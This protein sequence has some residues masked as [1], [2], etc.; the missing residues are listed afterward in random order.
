[1]KSKSGAND[2]ARKT[3]TL[4]MTQEVAKEKLKGSGPV[5]KLLKA[6]T[7]ERDQLQLKVAQL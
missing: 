3:I 5:S 6:V 4:D 2:V 7:E 1:M